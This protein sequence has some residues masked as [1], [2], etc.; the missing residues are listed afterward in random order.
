[1]TSLPLLETESEVEIAGLYFHAVRQLGTSLGSVIDAKFREKDAADWFDVIRE[2]R[3]KQ[4]APVYDD[5]FDPRF[6][7][8]EAVIPGSPVALAIPGFGTE[9]RESAFKL[10]G[11]INKWSHFSVSPTVQNLILVFETIYKVASL[12]GLDI[13]SDFA[14]SLDRLRQIS[15][16]RWTKTPSTSLIE[17]INDRDAE[18]YARDLAKKLET[19]EKRPP[20]G[21]AWTGDIGTRKIVIHKALRDV[22][23][24][25]VSIRT[26][27]L[28]NAEEV[29][30][31]WLRYYPMGG[32]ASVAADGAVMGYIKGTAH[33][34]GWLGTQQEDEKDPLGFFLEHD[35]EFT[36]TDVLD[37]ESGQMLTKVA[38][39]PVDWIIKA[40]AVGVPMDSTFN[41][42]TYGQII[43]YD[44]NG[45]A[46][47]IADIH[48]AVWFPGHL[49]G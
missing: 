2:A 45:L 34:I 49:P 18:Q 30:S 11:Q 48:N 39:E 1:L 41:V 4:K 9:W 20:V 35:Y 47:K 29:I 21:S 38:T 24:N 27:L 3:L 23:E 12:S 26:S 42:T 31:R 33:L 15:D 44:E 19:M 10:K 7:I 25:G 17:S 13:K 46:H 22:T 14:L 6:L 37:I 5:P 8:K 43:F 40:L 32:E 28:P 16:G 36:G